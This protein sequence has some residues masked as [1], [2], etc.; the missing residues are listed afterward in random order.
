MNILDLILGGSLGGLG[1]L[2]GGKSNDPI[3]IIARKLGIPENLARIAA[4]AL[5][6]ALM[7]GLQRNT[8]KAGGF[9]SLLGALQTG[10]HAKYVEDPDILDDQASVEDG[11]AILG[12]I[13]GSKDVSRN[14]AGRAAQQTGIDPAILKKMLPMLAGVAM[15]SMS[16]EMETAGGLSAMGEARPG[17]PALDALSSLLQGGD[18]QDDSEMDDLLNLAKRYF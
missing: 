10:Q 9:E 13:L 3:A 12:H 1:G 4:A 7:K 6:P 2:G 16:R 11:N 17:S 15:G 5:L 8:Q 14:V 18:G